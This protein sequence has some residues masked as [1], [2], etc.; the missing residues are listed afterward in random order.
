[1]S[2]P[3][4]GKDLD[5]KIF[6]LFHKTFCKNVSLITSSIDFGQLQSLVL[7]SKLREAAVMDGR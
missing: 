5:L 7:A 2:N 3:F 6:F 4:R 1:M